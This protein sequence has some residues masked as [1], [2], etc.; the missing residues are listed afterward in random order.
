MTVK[1]KQIFHFFLFLLLAAF[2]GGSFVAIKVALHS[3]EPS[4]AA[5]L[6]LL[7][8]FCALF[9]VFRLQKRSV[10]LPSGYRLKIWSLGVL[11]IALPFG[12]LFWG[13]QSVSPGIAGILNGSV[14]IW[15]SLILFFV[16][17]T[18]DRKDIHVKSILGIVMGFIGILV[19]FF[20][21]L[22]NNLNAELLGALA[23]IL[24]AV[25]YSLGNILNRIVLT[26]GK[27]VSVI[28]SLFHQHMASVVALFLFS[29]VV[30]GAPDWKGFFQST[31]AILSTLYL[32][33]CSTAF[34]LGIYFYLLKEW[35]SVKVS[36]VAYLIPVF[37]ILF[38][39]LFFGNL[40]GVYG[41]LGISLI[42]IG[43]F[44]IRTSKTSTK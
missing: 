1:Q 41:F 32:G 24:M 22:R 44:F 25:C 35:G 13:E 5:A 28:S 29:Y 10:S 11:S 6:R 37:A 3:V 23:I 18:Q 30:V 43:V 33:V 21:L 36:S 8:A 17:R 4:F 39:S 31:P 9:I 34:A 12:L 26:N 19:V 2:W 16:I 7:V 20:P 38:D 27:G 15:T 40:P 42:F 14:P